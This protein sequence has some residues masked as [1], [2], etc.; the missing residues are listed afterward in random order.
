MAEPNAAKPQALNY[1]LSVVNDPEADPVRRDKA[2]VT[3]AQL[4]SYTLGA[5]GQSSNAAALLDGGAKPAATN[6]DAAARRQARENEIIRVATDIARTAA[7][8]QVLELLR[9]SLEGAG[10]ALADHRAAL[11]ALQRENAEL[12]QRLDAL[13]AA[14]A[15]K[16]AYRDAWK[17]ETTY[18]QND[19][20]TFKGQLWQCNHETTDKPG[21]SG[22]WRLKH[23]R[24]KL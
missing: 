17:A 8:Q 13:E 2:A 19:E 1:L 12:K 9:L 15:T 3:L 6:G 5:K 16:T 4:S 11:G 18:R 22:A 14:L 24:E 21:M 20:I 10:D 7:G 23:K